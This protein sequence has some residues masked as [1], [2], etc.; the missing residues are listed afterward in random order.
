[1]LPRRRLEQLKEICD[2]VRHHH[3]VYDDWGFGANSAT[4]RASASLFAGP[5]G[6][7]QDDGREVLAGDV[8]LRPV[9]D[10]PVR[11]GQQVHRRD[12]EEPGAIFARGRSQQRHPVL[13]RGGRPVRQANRGLRR[14]RPLRQHR[15]QLP[16]AANWRSTRGRSCSPPTCAQT[17][18]RRSPAASGYVVEFPFPDAA[19]RQRIW[20]S[21]FPAEAPRVR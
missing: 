7:R 12:R 18:T 11:R 21:H 6:H 20:E 10:R 1:M 17:S 2:Q 9:Q 15:D 14:A 16:A 5:P 19:H 3:L 4:A 13:R 8:G